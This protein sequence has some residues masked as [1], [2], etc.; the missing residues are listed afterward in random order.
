MT[1]DAAEQRFP[2]WRLLGLD[3]GNARIGVA[4]SDESGIVVTPYRVIRRRPE[5]TA[6][7]AIA[8]IVVAESV[9]GVVAGLPLR[10]SGEYSEQTH[11]T[12][13]FVARLTAH[14]SIPVV[15]WDE[16]YTTV[17]AENI[18]RERGVK[19]DR[20][21]EQIDAIAAMV[22]LQDYLDAHRPPATSVATVEM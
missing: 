3:V 14:V 1:A 17:E 15:T 21:R 19:R 12:A 18:L 6:L 8:S 5:A 9:V 2:S 22:I 4:L 13:A 7:A 11:M 10:L 16:R 20:W